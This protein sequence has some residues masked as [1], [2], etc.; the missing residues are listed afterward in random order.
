[1]L[2]TYTFADGTPREVPWEMKTSGV[3][4]R[5]GG[6]RLQLGNHPYAD[7]LASLGLPKRAMASGSVA[8]VDMTFGDARILR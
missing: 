4:L 1:M 8:N 2:K 3:R 6:A 7:E 5:P